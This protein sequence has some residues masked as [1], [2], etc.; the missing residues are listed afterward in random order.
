MLQFDGAL[1]ERSTVSD[2]S[3][4]RLESVS[5]RDDAKFIVSVNDGVLSGLDRKDSNDHNDDKRAQ[6]GTHEAKEFVIQTVFVEVWRIV[7]KN[8]VGSIET[9]RILIN[10]LFPN[11]SIIFWCI[12]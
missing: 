8:V 1:W 12:S 4:V 2:E 3:A 5:V 11:F 7:P 10:Y 6:E 9:E